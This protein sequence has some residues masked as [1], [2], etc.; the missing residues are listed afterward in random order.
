M[1]RWIVEQAIN[2]RT[3]LHV[4]GLASEY[5]TWRLAALLRDEAEI[6][7]RADADPVTIHRP[8]RPPLIVL[9]CDLPPH[10]LCQ[11]LPEELCHAHYGHGM[12]A[13]LRQLAPEDRH[14]ERLARVWDWK[15]EALAREF[16]R[17]WVYGDESE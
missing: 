8:E 3:R 13:L 7:H 5:D 1:G 2:F 17:V 4:R 16:A 14:I 9:P 11:V 6:L 12:G 10:R 15:E